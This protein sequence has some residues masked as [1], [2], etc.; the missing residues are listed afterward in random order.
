MSKKLDYLI[1]GQGLAGTLLAHFLLKTGKQILLIDNYHEGAA[2]TIAAGIINPITGRR[3]VKSWQIDKLI[4]FARQT[5]HEIEAALAIKFFYPNHIVRTLFNR[6]EENDWLLR[7]GQEGYAPYML[8]KADLGDI[9]DYTVPAFS[10]GEVQQ[11][12][13][14]EVNKLVA[15]YGLYFKT[16]GLLLEE[17]F[18]FDALKIQAESLNYKSYTVSNIIFCEGNQ[19][20]QNPYFGHLPFNGAKGEVLIIKIPGVRLE[21][22][23]KHRIF[24]VPLEGDK[25]WVGASYDWDFKNDKPTAEGRDFLVERLKEVLKAPFE[26]LEHLAAIRPTVKDRRPFLG[27]HPKFPNLFIFNGLGTKGASLGPYWAK[28]MVDFLV[29]EMELDPAVNINRFM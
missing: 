28:H 19:A 4:P 20:V 9:K 11:A 23:F 18:D 25:Y 21:K 5:Y 8:G 12:A 2:S 15:N 10:Y 22:L 14:V 24:I 1:V 6:R 27:H 26:I 17:K 13:Q 16:Q 7:L 3:Y 29:N